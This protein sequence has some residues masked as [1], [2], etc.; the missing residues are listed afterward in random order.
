MM[1]KPKQ[2]RRTCSVIKTFHETSGIL[3]LQLLSELHLIILIN[4]YK[5]ECTIPQ[6]PFSKIKK[7][8]KYVINKFWITKSLCISTNS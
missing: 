7:H 2:Y 1:C 3:P 6:A 4:V 5:N 8:E